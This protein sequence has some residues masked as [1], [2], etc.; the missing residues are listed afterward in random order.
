M[1]TEIRSVATGCPDEPDETFVFYCDTDE[2][3]VGQR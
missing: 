3:D 1:K 2:P